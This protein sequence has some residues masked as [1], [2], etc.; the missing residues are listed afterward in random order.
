MVALAKQKNR[1]S[2]VCF[3]GWSFFLMRNPLPSNFVRNYQ[4]SIEIWKYTVHFV[5]KYKGEPF[6]PWR[7]QQSP[8]RRTNF[9]IHSFSGEASVPGTLNKYFLMDGWMDGCLVIW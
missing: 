8:E 6:P 2:T 1:G 4:K 5:G 3:E 7:H 9:D